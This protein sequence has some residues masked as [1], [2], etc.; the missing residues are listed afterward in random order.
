[1]KSCFAGWNPS[2]LGWNLPPMASD[3]IKSAIFNLP[4]GR[5]HRAAISSTKWIYS[6]KTFS[7][8]SRCSLLLRYYFSE[9]FGVAECEIISSG[10]CE[11]L[12]LRRN[13]KWNLPTFASA[14]ISHLRSKYFTAYLFHLPAGQISLK[15]PS[16]YADGFFMAHPY[17]IDPWFSVSG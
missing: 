12:L 7:N 6:D 14:N 16:A 5:F 2:E 9:I 15:K 17:K 10:N 3:E 4:Q 13:V 11:I 1:M 8:K